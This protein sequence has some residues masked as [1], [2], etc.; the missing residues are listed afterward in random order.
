[1][2]DSDVAGPTAI[3]L[4]LGALRFSGLAMGEGPLAPLLGWP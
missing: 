3:T 2:A 4:T 1:M